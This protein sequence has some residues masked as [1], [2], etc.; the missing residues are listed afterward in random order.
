MVKFG[1][2]SFIDFFKYI[3]KEK[4]NLVIVLGD[5]YEVF[6]FSL[7]AYLAGV[8]ICHLHGGS[9]EWIFDEGL[10]HSISKFSKLHFVVHKNY[11]KGL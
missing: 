10:R 7:C 4:P 2:K 3:I 8:N 11:K 6:F 9:Y 1:S 5:R